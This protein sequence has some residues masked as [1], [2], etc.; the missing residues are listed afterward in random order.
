MPESFDVKEYA[1]TILAQTRNRHP[2][3]QFAVPMGRLHALLNAVIN[4]APA[5]AP[6]KAKLPEVKPVANPREETITALQRNDGAP[7]R[8]QDLAQM[9]GHA[10]TAPTLSMLKAMEKAGAVKLDKET[11][12]VRLA[13]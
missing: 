7:I 13:S 6:A 10:S 5:A 4:G 12:E 1:T 8:V 3:E 11:N 2:Q 9:L